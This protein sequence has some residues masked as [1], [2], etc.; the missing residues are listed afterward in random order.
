MTEISYLS[1]IELNLLAEQTEKV[2]NG[3]DIELNA[4]GTEQPFQCLMRLGEK[5]MAIAKKNGVNVVNFK[6]GQY[7]IV[8]SVG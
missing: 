3:K 4:S 5:Y 1:K 2:V 8:V 6:V 7:S